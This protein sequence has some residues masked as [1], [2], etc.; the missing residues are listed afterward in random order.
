MNYYADSTVGTD[1]YGSYDKYMVTMSSFLSIAY[2]FADDT[3]A[4]AVTP[5]ET[6]GYVV[7][8]S[9]YFNAVMATVGDYSIQI[10]TDA[11]DHYDSVGLGRIQKK[12]VYSA[13]G[14]STSCTSEPVYTTPADAN[15][16]DMSLG[17]VW[18]VDGVRF[19]LAQMHS[20]THKLEIV[21]ETEDRVEFVITYEGA[22]LVGVKAVQEHYVLT[23]DGLTVTTQLIGAQTGGM[24][25][26]VPLLAYNGS[27]ETVRTVTDNGFTV[28]LSG[29]DYQVASNAESVS[30]EDTRYFNRN[31]EYCMGIL[32]S[33]D[34]SITVSFQLN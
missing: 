23:K 30:C 2:L 29:Q 3:I 15:L 22:E 18:Y 27:A 12:G 17:A 32:E 26:T 20:L 21:S 16:I 11:D 10:L 1:S 31:G 19:S 33:T 8:T 6:G 13:L 4:E 24:Q 34:H 5:A 14:L 9:D 28:T 25:Y 7:E